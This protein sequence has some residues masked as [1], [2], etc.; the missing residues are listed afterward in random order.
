LT[1]H[2]SNVYFRKV[3]TENREPELRPGPPRDLGADPLAMRALAHPIRIRLLEELTFRG[4]L[5]ATQA[6]AHVGESPSSCSFHLR[7]L[8]KYGFVEEAGGGTG[9]QRPWRVVSLGSRWRS[10]PGT[11]AAERTAADA[12]AA[13]VRRRDRELFDDYLAHRDELP[14]AWTE[15]AIHSSFGGWLTAEELTEIG[16]RL[17]EVWQPFLDRLRDPSARPPGSRLVHMFAHGFPRPEPTGAE[18]PDA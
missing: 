4:P 8:A 11:E 9:R 5:T 10:G 1:R 2:L 14:P 12:L 6:A 17:L 13:Q 7:T 15:A 16:E 3:S 18:D